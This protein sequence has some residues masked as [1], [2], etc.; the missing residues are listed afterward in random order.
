LGVHPV[1]NQKKNEKH[2][3]RKTWDDAFLQKRG[4]KREGMISI[5]FPAA[6]KALQSGLIA[7]HIAAAVEPVN[8]GHLR[9]LGQL[10]A[11]GGKPFGDGS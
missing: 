10:I 11:G 1:L 8:H 6:A 2:R 7:G 5:S 3:L 4:Y 9:A